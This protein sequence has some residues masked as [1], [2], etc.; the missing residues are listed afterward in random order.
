MTIINGSSG[1]APPNFTGVEKSK[2]GSS[3]IS[4]STPSSAPGAGTLVLS[5]SGP[6]ARFSTS[7]ATYPLKLLSPSPLPSQPPNLALAYTLAYGGG[8]VAG[9]LISLR[10]DVEQNGGLCLLTQGSTK[11]FKSR[12]GIRPLSHPHLHH[13]TGQNDA[14]AGARAKG[15]G[16]EVTTQRMHITLQPNSFALVL[17]DSISPF[18]GSSYI[19]SQ[20]FVLPP[21]DTASVLILDWVNSGRG[22]T[23]LSE[24]D[25]GEIW[26]MDNYTSTNEILLGEKRIMREK[27]VLDNTECRSK[28][29]EGGLSPVAGKLAPYHVYATLLIYGPHLVPLL[30]HLRTVCDK[31]TQFQ[32]QRTPDLTWSFSDTSGENGLGGVLRIAGVAVE[33]V[34]NWIRT[35]LLLG[36]MK[37]IVGE[38]LWSRVI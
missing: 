34:R 7:Q 3:S 22:P 25:K 10:I 19:Q 33:D 36:G 20:R 27:M 14:P 11:V 30:E 9:D 35:A 37:D 31:T 13:R 8:L 21:D 17:P 16:K 29:I 32:I 12:P 18:K 26:S 1:G 4:I 5:T 2:V 28:A 38:G 24:G 6:R 15:K 23:F